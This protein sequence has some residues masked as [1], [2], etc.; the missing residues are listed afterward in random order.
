M[1]N[2]LIECDLK[3]KIS[4]NFVDAYLREISMKTGLRDLL[5]LRR[6][7]RPFG[8]FCRFLGSII[9]NS[10]PVSLL[11]FFS[12]CIHFLCSYPTHY[13]QLWTKQMKYLLTEL[14]RYSFISLAILPKFT[15]LKSLSLRLLNS[16]SQEV[17]ALFNLTK[18]FGALA[19]NSLFFQIFLHLVPQGYHEIYFIKFNLSYVQEVFEGFG[20]VQ[21][22]FKGKD[23]PAS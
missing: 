17:N 23:W 8:W 3:A 18:F 5:F 12:S 19:K 2:V 1:P 16:G 13:D 6:E 22:D 11:I 20:R 7:N 4:Q 15:V 10:Y 14:S 21:Q 9:F